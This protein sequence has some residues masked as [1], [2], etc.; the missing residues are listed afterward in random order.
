M[1]TGRPNIQGTRGT[2]ITTK[3]P[4]HMQETWFLLAEIYTAQAIL[5]AWYGGSKVTTNVSRGHGTIPRARNKPL[6]AHHHP[7]I[8]STT[9]LS[10]THRPLLRELADFA[11]RLPSNVSTRLKCGSFRVDHD[12]DTKKRSLKS[13]SESSSPNYV[14]N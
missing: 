1:V 5:S 13:P 8:H 7:T 10:L 2:S 12:A 11:S 4:W 14:S 6:H 9:C 3:T